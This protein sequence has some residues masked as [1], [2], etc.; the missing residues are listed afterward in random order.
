MYYKT[1]SKKFN[2]HL[3]QVKIYWSKLKKIY[4]KKKNSLIQPLLVNDKFATVVKAKACIFNKFL[5][6][7]C[8]SLK[9]DSVLPVN[10]IFLSQSRL[11][12]LDFNED[13]TLK[14]IR[15]LNIYKL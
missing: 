5:A 1:L 7:Q 8:T 3:L 11:N 14:I 4:N 2:N 13:E 12:S 6:E 15:A 10:Q 9:N